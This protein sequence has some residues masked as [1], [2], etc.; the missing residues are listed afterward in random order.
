MRPGNDD[1]SSRHAVRGRRGVGGRRF[2]R[3][4]P[5]VGGRRPRRPAGTASRTSWSASRRSRS[6]SIPTAVD[7]RRHGRGCGGPGSRRRA[8]KRGQGRR[9]EIPVVFDGADLE[10]VA[11][12]CPLSVGAVVEL[13]AS[14]ELVVAFLGFAPGFA[15]L[16]GLPPALVD[17][18]RRRTPRPSVPGRV[19]AAGRRFRRHLP[20]VLTGRLA[21]R[22][23]AAGRGCS[24][25]TRHL[26]PCCFRATASASCPVARRREAGAPAP[27]P[28]LESTAPRTVVVQSPGMLSLVEDLGR[29][30]TAG[31]GVPRAGGA[32]PFFLR[33]R[34][35]AG[36][37]RR[38]RRP[39]WR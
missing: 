29:T 21:P 23:H 6:S 13:L 32:D 20:A 33:M 25:R 28:R 11:H 2:R 9:I 7:V 18:P 14:A 8:D 17:V 4:R 34:Q 35:P 27:R 26:S 5:P 38:R 3:G 12:L 16:V 31:L 1:A 39:R 15:Y 37:Q 24:I 36:G 30:G 22:R 10:E 19:R